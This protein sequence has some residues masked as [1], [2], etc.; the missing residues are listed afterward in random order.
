MFLLS[1]CMVITVSPHAMITVDVSS[2]QVTSAPK[3]S[4]TARIG[5]RTRSFSISGKTLSY[6]EK[7]KSSPFTKTPMDLSPIALFADAISS[8]T[9][10][11]DSFSVPLN[12][13]FS[14]SSFD[15]ASSLIAASCSSAA[16]SSVFF[17]SFAAFSSAFTASFSANS[18][19]FSLSVFNFFSALSVSFSIS[20]AFFSLSLSALSSVTFSS[21]LTSGEI[22]STPLFAANAETLNELTISTTI[23][24]TILI[25]LINNTPL[26]SKSSLNLLHVIYYIIRKILFSKWCL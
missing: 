24:I 19:A 14:S 18:S 8:R 11:L 9:S 10:C 7:S 22:S 2:F 3:V 13:V 4:I 6:F 26:I 20:F 5:T 23:I 25:F 1:G 16:F 21:V 15:F 12:F 17:A